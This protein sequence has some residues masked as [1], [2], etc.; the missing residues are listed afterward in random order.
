MNPEIKDLIE[1]SRYYGCNKEYVIAGGG[2]TSFKND[3]Y[4]WVKASGTSLA[5]I[6]EKGFV[7]LSRE[8]LRIISTKTYSDDV[9]KR[10]S[11]VKAD[12]YAAITENQE[13]R[14]SVETSLHEIIHMP[15]WF[16]LM[17]RGLTDCCVQKIQGIPLPG[18]LENQRCILNIL[19]RV[20]PFLKRPVK[21]WINIVPAPERIPRSSCL[22][23][24]VYLLAL[25]QPGK[26]EN[27][28]KV[29]IRRLK[30][31]NKCGFARGR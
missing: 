15:M 18:C 27:Y 21:G 16:I 28:T 22:R 3:Q 23:I 25:I 8:K 6:D 20:I 4:I 11:E 12:L 7:K 14:P 30:K 17:P 31:A 9:I 24:M 2:N 26:S 1:I 19:I 5:S 29:S 13:G 10:E